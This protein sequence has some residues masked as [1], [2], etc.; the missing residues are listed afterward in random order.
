M[1]DAQAA[2]P[3]A[4]TA[5]M[6]PAGVTKAADLSS[7]RSELQAGQRRRPAR[8]GRS[9]QF[10]ELMSK[11]APRHASA[12][13]TTLRDTFRPVLSRRFTARHRHTRH[14]SRP[15]LLYRARI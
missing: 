3:A 10:S 8:R 1:V 5:G 9:Q 15:D 12:A 14:Q 13:D 2:A 7:T 6:L 11:P 4:S